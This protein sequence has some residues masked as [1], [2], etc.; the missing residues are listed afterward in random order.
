MHLARPARRYRPSEPGAEGPGER[1]VLRREP[2]RVTASRS[3]PA[4]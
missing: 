4:S 3:L 2:Q 1:P